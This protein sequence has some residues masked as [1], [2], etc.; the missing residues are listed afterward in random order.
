M[1]QLRK[2]YLLDRWVI[3]ASERGKRPHQFKQVEGQEKDAPCY[4][5]PGHEGETPPE[6]YRRGTPDWSIRV[7]NNKFAA[8]TPVGTPSIQ[9]HNTFYTFGDAFGYH[10]VIVETRHHTQQLWDLDNKEIEEVLLTYVNRYEILKK[11]DGIAY[12]EIFKNHKKEAGTSIIHSHSQV[13]A[14]TK[15]P[16]TVEEECNACRDEDR[17]GAVIERE[18]GSERRCFENNDWIAFT[19][20]ASRQPFEIIIFP[21]EFKRT[22]EECN[23]TTLTDILG[24]ILR[25]LKEINA[26]FNYLLH[27]GLPD[28]KLRFHI[29]IIPRFSTWAGFELSG[30]IIN[31]MSPEGAA[32]FYRGEE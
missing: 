19:P 32:A 23:T 1:G 12:V 3:I 25:K 4:F 15:I 21:K 13:V 2:D 9:T 16:R 18:R 7:F 26:P 22:L 11:K 5:C 14:Y 6:L 17:Y 29:E 10:E 30:T 8:A 24:K 20:Y 31:T 28:S 27:Y